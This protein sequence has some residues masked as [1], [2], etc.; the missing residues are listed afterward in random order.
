[1]PAELI[2]KPVWNRVKLGGL[3]SVPSSSL[4][5]VGLYFFDVSS[6]FFRSGTTRDTGSTPIRSRDISFTACTALNRLTFFFLDAIS[7]I[8]P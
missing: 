6:F 2:N 4:S 8:M 7:D 1:V 5:S 3:Y